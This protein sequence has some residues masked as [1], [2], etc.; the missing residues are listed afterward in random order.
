MFQLR[1]EFDDFCRIF[2]DDFHD[3]GIY[4]WEFLYNLHLNKDQIWS[5]YL[6]NLEKVGKSRESRLKKKRESAEDNKTNE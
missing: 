6:K 4:S 5:T 3:S 1:A 2:F